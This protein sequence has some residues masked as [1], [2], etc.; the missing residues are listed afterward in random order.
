VIRS[1]SLAYCHISSIAR[2]QPLPNLTTFI[3]DFSQIS[4]FINFFSIS[5]IRKLSLIRTP[6]AIAPTFVISALLV[7]PHL[8]SLN[9]R[10]VP[11]LQIQRASRYPPIAKALVNAG[12]FAE[13][14]PPHEDRLGELSTEFRVQPP[15]GDTETPGSDDEIA[16]EV[17]TFEQDL[18]QLWKKHEAIVERVKERCD[19]GSA[20]VE[21]D[22]EKGTEPERKTEEMLEEE[23]EE[24][25]E[26]AE[27]AD[28]TS[29][30][31]RSLAGVLKDNEIEVDEG[32]LYSSVLRAVDGVC[33]Q[34][35]GKR[36]AV[37][38]LDDLTD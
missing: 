36:T 20:P 35:R 5:S 19:R 28:G 9:G 12:W 29:S 17:D 26:E 13:F 22:Q 31:I 27:E 14:P 6:V 7:C 30:I 10:Q 16:D 23:E 37:R 25:K 15:T 24:E 32:D 2:L 1:L 38:G 33:K 21:S 34:A 8:A 11:A 4:S 18:Q 3:A